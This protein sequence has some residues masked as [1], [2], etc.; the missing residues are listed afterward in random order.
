VGEA[1]AAPDV[2]VLVLGISAEAKTVKEA[3][4]QVQPAMSR[5]LESLEENGI[6]EKD[7]QTIEFEVDPVH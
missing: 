7:I 1:S 4:S 6:Q 3:N 2:A 5:L